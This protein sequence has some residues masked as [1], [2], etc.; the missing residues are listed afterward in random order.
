[1]VVSGLP[2]PNGNLHAREVSR[3]ALKLLIAVSSFKIR[4]RPKDQLNLR[5][6]IHSGGFGW[7]GKLGWRLGKFKV[8][9]GF[10]VG[11]CMEGVFLGV[12]AF[13]HL[14]VWVIGRLSVWGFKGRPFRHC[15]IVVLSTWFFWL[16]CGVC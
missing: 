8:R 16:G 1:M 9:G 2:Q 5:I 7:L 14:D 11:V 6:G 15:N 3:M 10:E 4:H 13:G 12:W